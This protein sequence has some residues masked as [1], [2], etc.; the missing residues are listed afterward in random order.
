MTP[1]FHHRRLQL[2]LPLVVVT[3]LCTGCSTSYDLKVDSINKA[4]KM[5]EVVAAPAKEPQSYV[6]QNKNPA[7]DPE[8]LRY[9]EAAQYVKTALSG[10][11]LYEASSP[12]TAEMIVEVDFGIDAPK[13]KM[14]ETSVPVYAQTGGGVRYQQVSV[15]GASGSTSF[16]T[17]PVYD[18]PHVELVGY[19]D[20]IT[21]VTVYEKYLRMSARENREVSEG[22]PPAEIWSI[23]ISTE[24]ES[25]DL[26]KYLPLLASASV[27]YIGK[28]SN[29]EQTIKLKE[30]DPEVSFI[31]KGM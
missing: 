9:K 22:K 21:P 16:R 15:L 17:V 5:P 1:R 19:E 18:A 20:V 24:D 7:I 30:N 10:K 25:K 29:A 12:A 6:I 27:N 4:D 11:G 2:W 8:S 13:T 26:R 28:D 23:H 14:E 31:K 3:L